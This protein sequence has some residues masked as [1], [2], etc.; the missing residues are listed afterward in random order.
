MIFF[1]PQASVRRRSLVGKLKI[2]IANIFNL[3]PA[4][5]GRCVLDFPLGKK[6]RSIAQKTILCAS[7]QLFAISSISYIT[8]FCFLLKRRRSWE[9]EKEKYFCIWNVKMSC[10]PWNFEI[11]VWIKLKTH[12][13]LEKVPVTL[14]LLSL[15]LSFFQSLNFEMESQ[16]RPR[17]CLFPEAF[18]LTN[19]GQMFE[20]RAWLHL[21]SPCEA[22]F[23]GFF[24][25][26]HP[27]L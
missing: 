14:Y 26:P 20:V 8:S 4:G 18:C 16:H 19:K 17:K 2:L 12:H 13:K 27:L 10:L 23:T 1:P 5:G 15:T 6:V 22:F 24:S 9:N 21:E 11:P 25:W 3:F 7:K